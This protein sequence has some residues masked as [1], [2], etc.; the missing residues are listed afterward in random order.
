MADGEADGGRQIFVRS[1]TGFPLR[2]EVMVSGQQIAW[3][4]SV[5]HAFA[6]R[7]LTVVRFS[8]WALRADQPAPATQL[9][10]CNKTG[11]VHA[12]KA[13]GR[14]LDVMRALSLTTDPA[15]PVTH[16]GFRG[17]FATVDTNLTILVEID[18]VSTSIGEVEFP[19][20]GV[21]AGQ[22]DW[23]F[24]AG[25]TNDSIAQHRVD[26][27]PS[28]QWTRQW[29][30]YFAAMR[31]I[32]AE[33]S[34]FVVAPAK[35]AVMPERHRI[36][37]RAKTPIT[38]LL[39]TYAD[40][41]F[42]PKNELRA[43]RDFTYSRTDTHWT[44]YGARIACEAMLSQLGED[45]PAVP[46][47]YSVTQKPG[48][49]GDKLVPPEKARSLA[50]AWPGEPTL[51]FDNFVLH[52][53]NIRIWTNSHAPSKK[54]VLIFGGSSSDQMISYLGAS[55]S[56]VVS[57]YGVGSWD[58]EII[59]QEQPDIVI[60]QTNERFLVIPPAPHFNSLTVARQ[61]IAGGHVTVRNDIAA[62]LQQ[63]ADL[64]EEWYLSRH[65]SLSIV[66]K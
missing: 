17:E 12:A 2:G 35:E 29:K 62:S 55:Y 50:A 49:L 45:L 10:F 25:D 53:G 44:D 65:L 3:G 22:D 40:Q 60:L 32:P 20:P 36:R 42:F 24:L 58:P 63:F 14:R 33:K 7:D 47:L 52:H 43:D 13:S 34:L 6:A 26:Y 4:I 21:V 15:D 9:L 27:Q 23:L 56:R 8:A 19:A 64:G 51:V 1:R 28:D 38:H 18:G 66:R 41:V 46:K 37:R 30:E 31:L 57:I 61:K 5:S 39:S 11:P 59:T 54:T 48:D 16:C